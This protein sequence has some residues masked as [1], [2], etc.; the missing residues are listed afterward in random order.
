MDVFFAR[1]AIFDQS[2]S[3]WGYELLFRSGENSYADHV[4]GSY[5]TAHV[6]ANTLL[7]SGGTDLL[8]GK[9]ALVNFDEKLL[10]DRVGIGLPPE[11]VVIEVLE[12]VAATPEVLAACREYKSLGYRLALD[13]FVFQPGYEGLVELADIVKIDFQ[14][15]PLQAQTALLKRLKTKDR[16]LL[17]EKVE[18]REEFEWS[19]K[20]GY[21][22]FQGYFFARPV[23]VKKNAIPSSRVS[24]IAILKELQA[25]ELDFAA[26]E[27]RI[28]NDVGL[29]YR[30]LSYVNSANFAVRS[31]IT[32]INQ[33]LML[34]GEKELRRWMR[35]IAMSNLG[36]NKPGELVSQALVR[37]RLMEAMAT[38]RGAPDPEEAF[39]AGMFSLLDALLDRPLREILQEM[40]VDR[41]LSIYEESDASP[42]A[43]TFQLVTSYE[44]ADWTSTDRLARELSLDP[45]RVA[46]IYRE[47]LG[48]VSRSLS[49]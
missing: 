31:S 47:A 15:T 18:T 48:W 40:R 11:K 35:V 27:K 46:E 14:L 28:R 42:L 21:D 39:F 23:I 49:S 20:S 29:S 25:E 17:A 44:R 26:I 38:E 36:K 12:T 13:D 34:L 1:Q 6:L 9:P 32:S 2:L 8:N 4:S 24:A 41:L 22:L 30:L 37:A 7:S 43:K 3:V 45:A 19:R 33:A 10:L 16:L 5:A